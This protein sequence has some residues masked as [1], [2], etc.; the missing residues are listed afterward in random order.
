MLF[1]WADDMTMQDK[2]IALDTQAKIEDFFEHHPN[3]TFFIDQV[4]GFKERDE[5][6]L[7]L[8]SCRAW[9]K[10]VLSTSANYDSYLKTV[11]QQNTEETCYVYNGF[12]PVSLSKE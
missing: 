12:T 7:W 10:A 11:P 2:I 6:K 1:A 8:D 5:V 4:N 3:L 9:T